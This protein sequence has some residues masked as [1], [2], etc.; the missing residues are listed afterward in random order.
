LTNTGAVETFL[1]QDPERRESMSQETISLLPVEHVEIQI[2]MD[3]SIDLTLSSTDVARRIPLERDTF[4]R[5]EP[6]AEHGFSALLRVKR[7]NTSGTVLYDTGLNPRNL[8]YNVDALEIKLADLQSV[9]LSHG[10][11]DHA[12][13]LTGLAQRLGSRHLPLLLHPDAY[14]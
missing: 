4:E 6:V 13:G 2:I 14:L 10:H 11:A 7:G 1:K 5:P 3:N 8:L 9:I 12:M